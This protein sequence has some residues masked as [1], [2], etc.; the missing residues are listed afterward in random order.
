MILVSK[1]IRTNPELKNTLYSLIIDYVQSGADPH[2]IITQ[3]YIDEFLDDNVAP[4]NSIY[5]F[6]MHSDKGLAQVMDCS[7]VPKVIG[8]IGS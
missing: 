1:C 3:E 6:A 5:D 8:D 2:V 7:F 4:G